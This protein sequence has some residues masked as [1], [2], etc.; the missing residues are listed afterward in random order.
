MLRPF[1]VFFRRLFRRWNAVLALVFAAALAAEMF[2]LHLFD[3]TEHRLGDLYMV[4]H[5]DEYH[6]DPDIVIVDIDDYSM[7]AMKDAAGLWPWPREIHADLLEGVQEFGPR[8]VVFDITF[9]EPDIRRPKSDA[10]FSEVLAG[11]SNVYLP[12]TWLQNTRDAGA[13]SV[14]KFPLRELAPAFGVATPG[15]ANASASLQ[16][17]HAVSRSAW[18][19]GLINRADDH[20]GVLRRYR[21]RTDVNNWQLPSVPARVAKDLGATLPQGKEFTMR[22]PA[23]PHMHVPYSELYKALYER[24]PDATPEERQKLRDTVQGKVLIIG[25]STASAF[26]HHRTPLAAD[27]PGVD[28]LAVALDNLKNARAVQPVPML[29][30]LVFGWLLLGGIAYYFSRRTNPLSIGALLIVTTVVALF[31]ADNAIRSDVLVPLAT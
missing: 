12:A 18:Q 3:T 17:P 8:A 15:A 9:T 10:R 6:A 22:W 1:S 27:Y 21:L 26:D 24:G 14:D 30:P 2:A 4:R 31:A 11:L 19:L 7:Q 16:L 28:V 20:D 25:V 23:Q 29:V 13:Y 5:A